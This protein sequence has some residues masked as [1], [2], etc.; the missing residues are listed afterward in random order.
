MVL[1]TASRTKKGVLTAVEAE[2]CA[3]PNLGTLMVAGAILAALLQVVQI[4]RKWRELRAVS[5]HVFLVGWRGA[6]EAQ[7][8][9]KRT[10][11]SLD[12]DMRRNII[13]IAPDS[14]QKQISKPLKSVVRKWSNRQTKIVY[15]RA[16][17]PAAPA[18]ASRQFPPEVGETQSL[19]SFRATYQEAS[20]GRVRLGHAIAGRLC[21]RLWQCGPICTSV[22]LSRW[23]RR[24]IDSVCV[25]GASS[26]PRLA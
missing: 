2:T 6:F 4:T 7:S 24:W 14:V 23:T 21:C 1:N 15:V 25:R 8:N 19:I 11:S 10:T 5:L 16:R 20:T 22:S 12:G 3:R 17:T 13:I 26:F 9:A 18:V